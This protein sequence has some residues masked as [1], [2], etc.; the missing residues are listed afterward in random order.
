MLLIGHRGAPFHF[1]ANTI[2]A[3]RAAY[4]FGCDWVECDCRVSSDGVIVLAHDPEVTDR[5]GA[6]YEIAGSTAGQLAEVDLGASQGVPRLEELADLAIQTGGSVVA[7]IKVDG[8]EDKIARLLASLAP[9]RKI[10]SGAGDEGRQRFR[11]IDP[12]IC[13]ALTVS[14]REEDSLIQRWDAIDTPA[15]CFEYPLINAERLADLHRRH[16]QVHAWT[17]DQ[18]EMMEMLAERGVDGLISNRPDL[19][20][21]IFKSS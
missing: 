18:P 2:A 11:Q 4:D 10:V 8:H 7:D 20:C 21:Q 15:V 5:S 3:F 13:L 6:R 14:R 1:P 19:L 12:Q 16:I 9:G 17:V